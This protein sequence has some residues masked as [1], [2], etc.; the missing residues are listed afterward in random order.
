MATGE[1]RSEQ[2][3]LSVGGV[4]ILIEQYHLI[5]GA[6]A[7]AHNRMAGGDP[8]C[9]RH[10]VSVVNDFARRLGR[11]ISSNERQQLL[12]GPLVLKHIGDGL[13]HA[14]GQVSEAPLEPRSGRQDILL[15]AQMLGHL[16]GQRQHCGGHGGWRPLPRVRRAVVGRDHPGRQLP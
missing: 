7:E 1:E 16:A 3:E 11:C 13:G 2:H 15:A 5:A 9:Q 8:R 14:T 6:L 10:L 12:A 4:L